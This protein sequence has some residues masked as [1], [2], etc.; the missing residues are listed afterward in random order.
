MMS[1]QSRVGRYT[2]SLRFP[3][4]LVITAVLFIV[5]LLVPDMIP[6]VDEVLLGLLV[7]VFARLRKPRSKNQSSLQSSEKP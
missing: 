2:S 5:D 4:L 3:V 1:I 6:F 7:A